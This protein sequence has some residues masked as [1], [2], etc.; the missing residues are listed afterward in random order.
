MLVA[1]SNLI[2]I[3]RHKKSK[4]HLRELLGFLPENEV[5][6]LTPPRARGVDIPSRTKS[7]RIN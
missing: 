1:A 3:L 5:Q 2:N 6:F 4:D 7:Q